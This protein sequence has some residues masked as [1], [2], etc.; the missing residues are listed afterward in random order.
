MV[1]ILYI[2]DINEDN[3]DIISSFLNNIESISNIDYDILTNGIAI[4]NDEKQICGYI[5]YEKFSEY[6]LIRY[7]IYQKNV[8]FEYIKQMYLELIKKASDDEIES[9]ISIGNNNDVVN[10]FKLLN[11]AGKILGAQE[12]RNGIFWQTNLYK[13]LYNI[14]ESNQTWRAIYGKI[15]VY[16]KDMEILLKVLALSYYSKVKSD[17]KGEHIEVDFS[18]FSWA[19]I[20]E[21]YSSLAIEKDL[22]EEIDRLEKY[23]ERICLV[24]NKE[25]K[26][27]KAVFEAVFV[28]MCFVVP[29]MD[30]DI[31]YEWLCNVGELFGSIL[32]SKMSVEE[33]LTIAYNAV[34]EKYYD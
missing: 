11:S 18:G 8:D 9:F 29:E 10:I 17:A 5:T 27:R 2:N 26:C 7:F 31:E 15:S 19:K 12:I 1:I 28:A 32:S 24:N 4:V 3:K 16:S 33:R 14:N 13:R 23:L 22:N 30:K 25:L 21:E 6:G 20:M 34:K